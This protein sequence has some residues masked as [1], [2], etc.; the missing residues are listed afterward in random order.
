MHI[1]ETFTVVK[2]EVHALR[3]CPCADCTAERS[4]LSLQ[5]PSRRFLIPPADAY[6]LG[7]VPRRSP[8]GSV[9]RQLLAEQNHVPD[10]T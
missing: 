10:E 5:I 6:A 4:R 2:H 8:C 3:V 1:P 9:A 7:L